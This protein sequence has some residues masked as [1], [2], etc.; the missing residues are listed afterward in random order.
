MFIAP[1][2]FIHV[3]IDGTAPYLEASNRPG[4]KCQPELPPV[5][6]SSL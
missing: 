5:S 6:P 3:E 1:E 4:C 2:S